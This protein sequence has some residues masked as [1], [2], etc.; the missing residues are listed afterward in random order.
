MITGSKRCISFIKNNL[1]FISGFM[2]LG[3]IQVSNAVIQLLLFPLIIHVTGLAGFG[4]VMVANSYA[5]INALFINYGT[6]QSGIKDVALY[7]NDREQLS[8]IFYTAYYSRF[9]LCILSLVVLAILYWMDIPNVRYFPFAF[10]IIFAE[11]LNPF[12]FFVGIE[13]VYLYNFVNLVSKVFSALLIYFFI[14][15]PGLGAWINFYLGIINV[16]AYFFLSLYI[17]KKYRLTYFRISLQS[18]TVF[19]KQNFFLVG[20]NLSVQLQQSVF[21]FALA[22]AGNTLILGTYSFCDK[23]VW[24]FRLL[25]I[26]FSNAIFPRAVNIYKE[27]PAKWKSHRKKITRILA[28]F[29]MLAAIA[30][31]LFAPLI[32]RIFTKTDNALAIAYTRS[33]CLVPLIAALNSMNVVDLLLKNKYNYI[34]IIAM[35]L[36]A[37]S[38]IV[39]FIFLQVN[40]NSLFG[41]YQIIVEIF[42]L[43]LYLYFIRKSERNTDE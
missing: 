24:S 25:I 14:T 21:L 15:S 41:Y 13:K 19:F 3:S 23:I 39:S 30:L 35:I 6:N 33:V 37:I 7:K 20:N 43:P 10:T 28:F 42:S 29:F 22:S 18:L 4:I 17:I 38:V 40:N 11:V 2:H 16:V 8:T 36:L 9:I 1:G 32:V 5:A 27:N 12:F 26:A 34:F 31:I